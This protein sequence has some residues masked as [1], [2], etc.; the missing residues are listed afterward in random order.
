MLLRTHASLKTAVVASL[1]A[2][3]FAV[4]YAILGTEPRPLTALYIRVG[5]VLALM[6]WTLAD[7]RGTDLETILD[8]GLFQCMVWPVLMPWYLKRRYGRGA[9]ALIAVFL[10]LL[11]APRLAEAI[12]ATP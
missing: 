2:T 1:S 10:A 5:P 9:W 6:S 7:L 11:L 4:A 8:W 12:R 3:G